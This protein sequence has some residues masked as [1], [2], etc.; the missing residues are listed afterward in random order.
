METDQAEGAS[1]GLLLIWKP[2]ISQ[3]ER[4]ASEKH[5]L[6]AAIKIISS[7]SSF[8]LINV[9]GLVSS[10]LK[11]AFWSNL[12]GI[13]SQFQNEKLFIGGEF[14]SI[15]SLTD[16]RGGIIRLGKSQQEFNVWVDRNGL[17]EVESRDSTFTWNNRRLEFSNIVEK[18][19]R[20]FWL[21]DFTSFPYSFECKFLLCLGSDH[22]P[23]LL[24]F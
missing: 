6:M 20:F 2:T 12:D 17:L 18:I 15:R 19:D 24:S 7:N 16:K 23:L 9:Y 8:F 10:T 4:L 1:R 11:W 21:G 13:I 3:I 5:W 14:N 22:Y